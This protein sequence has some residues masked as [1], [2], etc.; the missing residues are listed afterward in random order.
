MEVC[1][2]DW[3]RPGRTLFVPVHDFWSCRGCKSGRNAHR[4]CASLCL[5]LEFDRLIVFDHSASKNVYDSRGK[6]CMS[7]VRE[8]ARCLRLTTAQLALIF[9][10]RVLQI[11]ARRCN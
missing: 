7:A 11:D 9:S 3:D 10:G 5:S 2:A 4:Y 8:L 1:I 6:L